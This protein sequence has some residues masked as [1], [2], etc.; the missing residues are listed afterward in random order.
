MDEPI[1]SLEHAKKKAR[2][3][4]EQGEAISD[5]PFPPG[6]RAYATWRAEYARQQQEFVEELNSTAINGAAA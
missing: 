5:C 6:S 2:K 3:A 1:V 4:F